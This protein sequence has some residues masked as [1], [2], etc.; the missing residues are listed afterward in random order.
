MDPTFSAEQLEK[1]LEVAR[2]FDDNG[3]EIQG[4]QL[5]YIYERESQVNHG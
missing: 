1:I 2:I 4:E 5:H 3:Y